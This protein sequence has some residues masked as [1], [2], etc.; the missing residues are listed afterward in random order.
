SSSRRGCFILFFAPH[1][2]VPPFQLRLERSEA[3]M[4]TARH[5]WYME[6]MKEV[7]RAR[8]GLNV[9]DVE[10]TERGACG[11]VCC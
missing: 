4:S 2:E 1:A 11:A 6:N 9:G 3:K 5:R 10:A 8:G 7:R